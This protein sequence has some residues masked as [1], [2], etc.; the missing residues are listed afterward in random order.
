MKNWLSTDTQVCGGGVCGN[1]SFS[2]Q[3]IISMD[4]RIPTRRGK[5]D[6]PMIRTAILLAMTISLSMAPAAADY[7]V[8]FAHLRSGD[9]ESAYRELRELSDRGYPVYQNMVA[10]MHLEGKGVEADPVL[11]HVWYTLS[12]SQGNEEA[13]R[14]K[15]E[16]EK[17]MSADQLLTSRRLAEEYGDLYVAPIRP[18]WKLE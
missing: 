11:A 14:L 5:G 15:A 3:T 6:R 18:N 17:G 10:R 16:L 7:A 9:Y 8:A 1:P 13:I 12:A 4:D 2:P